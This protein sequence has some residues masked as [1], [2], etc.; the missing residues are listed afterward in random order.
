MS[1]TLPVS[2]PEKSSSQTNKQEIFNFAD[3]LEA[4]AEGTVIDPILEKEMKLYGRYFYLEGFIHPEKMAIFEKCVD[5]I[6]NI[7]PAV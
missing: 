1:K 5:L 4:K 7:N 2:I 3:E 6:R